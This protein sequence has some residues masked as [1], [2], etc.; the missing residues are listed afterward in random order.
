MLEASRAGYQGPCLQVP[1]SFLGGKSFPVISSRFPFASHWPEWNC[2][3][4]FRPITDS[5]EWAYH[6]LMR[7]GM[8]YSLE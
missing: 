3:P 2:V 6:D 1:L 8:T 4:T 7:P 5:G